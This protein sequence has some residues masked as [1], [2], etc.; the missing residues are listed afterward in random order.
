MY[1]KNGTKMQSVKKSY[2]FVYD[3]H[4]LFGERIEEIN[5]M[6]QKS[7]HKWDA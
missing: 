2:S 4:T 5:K 3:F 7:I 1:K 6:K